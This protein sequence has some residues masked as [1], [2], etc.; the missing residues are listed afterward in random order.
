MYSDCT[1]NVDVMRSALEACHK[2]IVI[3]LHYLSQSILTRFG[4][5]QVGVRVLSLES[6][7]PVKKFRPDPSNWLRVDVG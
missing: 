5:V 6:P 1:G 2:G 7:P 4:A 3:I